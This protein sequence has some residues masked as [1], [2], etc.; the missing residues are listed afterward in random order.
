MELSPFNVNVAV[1]YPPD[2]DTPGL[3]LEETRKPEICKKIT[4]C[5]GLSSPEYVAERIIKGIENCR[6]SIYC[7]LDGWLLCNLTT[8]FGP[9]NTMFSAVVQVLFLGLFRL[10]AFFYRLKFRNIVNRGLKQVL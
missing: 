6:F 2:T 1:A 9:A 3:A 8:G 7:N 5:A 4:Q 10:V